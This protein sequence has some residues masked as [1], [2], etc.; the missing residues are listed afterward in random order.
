MVALQMHEQS[1]HRCGHPVQL[2]MSAD[3]EFTLEDDKC[4]ACALLEENRS[5]AGDTESGVSWR[6][7]II[8]RP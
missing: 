7:E 4:Y 8:R 3:T 5:S 1:I 2:S 6:A